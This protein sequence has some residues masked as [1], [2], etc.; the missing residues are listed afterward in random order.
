[1]R[2]ELE[3]LAVGHPQRGAIAAVDRLG[4]EDQHVDAAV[5]N[6]VVAAGHRDAGAAAGPG[7]QP[8][9]HAA[10]EIGHD[11][12]GDAGVNI[13]CAAGWRWWWFSFS[14]SFRSRDR[15]A[16]E[17]AVRSSSGDNTG[18][19]GS[20]AF[21]LRRSRAKG[22]GRSRTREAAFKRAAERSCAERRHPDKP[23]APARHDWRQ[24]PDEAFVFAISPARPLKSTG[25][26]DLRGDRD[27]RIM[28]LLR[29]GGPHGHD[30]R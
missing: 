28:R 25:Q 9:P 8:R 22:A 5:R 21:S 30:R 27:G 3:S 18:A 13:K 23:P 14:V 4:P 17:R 26:E 11:A 6:A 1:M 20:R 24:P 15:F 16:K 2:A 29:Q 7:L 10:L 19:L 12:L